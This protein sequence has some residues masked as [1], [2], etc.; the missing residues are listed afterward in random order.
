VAAAN[1]NDAN[2]A[3]TTTPGNILRTDMR[4]TPLRS[5]T[6]EAD[7]DARPD[8]R[9]EHHLKQIRRS[10][11]HRADYN[12]RPARPVPQDPWRNHASLA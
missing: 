10:T 9:R 11:K 8:V 3:I 7:P 6:I 5:V 2:D 1:A 12:S 4:D